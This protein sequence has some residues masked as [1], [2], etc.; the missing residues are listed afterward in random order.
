MEDSGISLAPASRRPSPSCHQS[1]AYSSPQYLFHFPPPPASTLLVSRRPT[2]LPGWLAALL[3][4]LPHNSTNVPVSFPA[5]Q[6]LTPLSPFFD[7]RLC[8]CLT[9]PPPPPGR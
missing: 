7:S 4:R 3:P 9:P 5:S 6:R 2:D 1:L 8:L